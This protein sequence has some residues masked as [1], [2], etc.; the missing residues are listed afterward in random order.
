MSG[1]LE[2]NCAGGRGY[3]CKSSTCDWLKEVRQSSCDIFPP[4]KKKKKNN[5]SYRSENFP[6]ELRISIRAV[7]PKRG[8][9]RA[10]FI[11]LAFTAADRWITPSVI[12]NQVKL[13]R[14]LL[15]FCAR[16]QWYKD[17]FKQR[18]MTQ[19]NK[20][21][22]YGL[23]AEVKSKVGLNPLS[24]SFVWYKKKRKDAAMKNSR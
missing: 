11:T 1:C 2:P 6:S 15:F 12:W 9:T 22:A 16:F 24:L 5:P 13:T 7:V 4:Q 23:S 17:T 8:Q 19:F 3:V 14:S 20:G 18:N 10:E 21:P